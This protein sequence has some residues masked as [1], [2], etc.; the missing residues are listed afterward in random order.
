MYLTNTGTYSIFDRFP[1]SFILSISLVILTLS[2]NTFSMI[3]VLQASFS[4]RP[5]T[6]AVPRPSPAG[7]RWRLTTR[8]KW[9]LWHAFFDLFHLCNFQ[10]NSY[11]C[12]E[13]PPSFAFYFLL[14]FFQ[15]LMPFLISYHRHPTIF[16]FFFR[17]YTTV[18]QPQPCQAI[19][20]S[21]LEFFFIVFPIS[22]FFLPLSYT[23]YLRG[24][25]FLVCSL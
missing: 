23:L 2:T 9:L 21:V 20:N 11:G 19:L 22:F 25:T 16:S 3:Q 6:A 24:Q 14:Y 18:C 5:G 8:L 13:I 10:F 7:H 4:Y 12:L 17:A 1:Q 15:F